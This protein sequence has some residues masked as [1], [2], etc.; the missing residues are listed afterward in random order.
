[1]APTALPPGCAFAPRCPL[2][3]GRCHREEPQ[4]WPAGDGHEVSCHR[5]DEVPHPATELFLEQRA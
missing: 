1:P 5:W 4:P 3:E 2:A